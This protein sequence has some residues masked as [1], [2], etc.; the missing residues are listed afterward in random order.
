MLNSTEGHSLL[1]CSWPLYRLTAGSH[2]PCL[3]PS[4]PPSGGAPTQAV[5]SMSSAL[6]PLG[7]HLLTFPRK[8]KPNPSPGASSLASGSL[9]RIKQVQSKAAMTVFLLGQT[10]VEAPFSVPTSCSPPSCSFSLPARLGHGFPS[11][12]SFPASLCPPTPS[13]QA[14]L[15]PSEAGDSSIQPQGLICWEEFVAVGRG[16]PPGSPSHGLGI[17]KTGHWLRLA[18]S[19]TDPETPG[20]DPPHSGQLPWERH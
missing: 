7:G 3:R 13:T 14:G 19:T 6:G 1:G 20:R 2:I 17:G 10:R 5:I 12:L 9:L 8:P 15:H 11:L 4:S 16:F 18:L